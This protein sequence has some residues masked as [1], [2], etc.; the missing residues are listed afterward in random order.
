MGA[1]DD[2]R[3]QDGDHTAVREPV[4]GQHRPPAPMPSYAHH[5][6]NPQQQYP[7]QQQYGYGPRQ[8]YRYGGPSSWG[9]RPRREY[10]IETKPFFLTSEFVGSSRHR[11]DRDH[12][13]LVGRVRRVAGVDLD[14][15]N[16][17]QLHDQPRDRQVRHPL[18]LH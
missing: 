7:P 11:G 5:Q 12:R 8:G 2:E 10:P 18:A 17:G 9:T 1:L 3:Y 16:L 4:A 13:G 6:Q 14:H 15:R